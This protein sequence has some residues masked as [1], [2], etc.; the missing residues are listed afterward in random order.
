M[1]KKERQALILREVNIR[2]KVLHNDLSNKLEVSEDTIRRDLQ[3]LAD[4]GKLVKVRGGA[5][6]R[7]FQVN[8]YQG[9]EIYKY[10]EKTAIARKAISLLSNGM[11]VLISGGTTAI[12]LARILPQ[13]LEVTFYTPSLLVALQL[14][15]H[16]NCDTIFIGGRISR[17]AKISTGGEVVSALRDIRPD[18]CLIGTNSIDS[19]VGITDSDWEV[20]DVKKAMIQV[21]E[22]VGVLTISDK[23]DSNQKIRIAP[24]SEITYLITEL[25]PDD[26]VLS[27]YKMAGIQVI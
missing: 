14:A 19:R 13:E 22:K 15:E 20:V 21:S 7:S 4:E 26:P 8:S 5:L 24:I 6:S 11:L 1:L 3:E 18:L 16:P 10:Q 12:E 17:N 23:L 27:P 25:E 2:N 9:S